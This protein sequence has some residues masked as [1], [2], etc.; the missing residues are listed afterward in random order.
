M[1]CLLALW[2]NHVIVA[3]SHFSCVTD[4]N[5]RN[6]QTYYRSNQVRNPMITVALFSYYY[7]VILLN[8]ATMCFEMG[9]KTHWYQNINGF[10]PKITSCIWISNEK[11]FYL[12]HLDLR[13]RTLR[14][15]KAKIIWINMLTL[16]LE[17]NN[18]ISNLPVLYGLIFSNITCPMTP[19]KP[20]CLMNYLVQTCI[21]FNSWWPTIKSGENRHCSRFCFSVTLK[22]ERKSNSSYN[23]GLEKES[24]W[25]LAKRHKMLWNYPMKLLGWQLARKL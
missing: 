23:T 1:S 14:L 17:Q 10:L 5:S 20:N 25:S 2:Y 21:I 8:L 19:R 6:C 12:V 22:I 15:F 11:L 3:S 9:N 7:N 24:L 18:G 16:I 4:G 13:S